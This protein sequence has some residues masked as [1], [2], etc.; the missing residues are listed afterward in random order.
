MIISNQ[1]KNG[2]L[3]AIRTLFDASTRRAI[4]A[5]PYLSS[6]AADL[7]GAINITVVDR[8]DLITTFKPN[9]PEQITK[10]FQIKEVFDFINGLERKIEFR[11]WIDNQLH[12]KVYIALADS[13]AAM[14]VSSANLTHNGLKDNH[15][16]GV[17]LS[18]QEQIDLV[19]EALFESIDYS[20]VTETQIKRAC[21]F[22]D[23]YKRDRSE[24]FKAPDFSEL[25][26]L[27]DCYK[28]HSGDSI[29]TKY[30]LKPYGTT[31]YP[32]TL[33]GQQDFS[34][35]HQNLHFSKRPPK[36]VRKGDI[37]IT[38][39]VGAGSILSYFRVTGP[40]ESVSDSMLEHEP[41]LERWPWYMEGRNQSREFGACWWEHNLS[42]HDLLKEF[43]DAHPDKAVTF[44]GGKTLGTL[45]RGSDKVRITPEFAHFIIERI[46]A[47]SHSQPHQG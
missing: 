2:H 13:H 19:A 46:E 32:I 6:N 36:S 45:N 28:D 16:W 25:D 12:G 47:A 4:I 18:D 11:L 40:L 1:R 41:H 33:E 37:V 24:G 34:A 44:V 43:V 27:E 22:A 39:A 31:E 26:I 42:R 10:P 7:L 15:E 20:E 35:L 23:Q 14:I 29:E 8:F 21:L 3:E 5:S 38:T 30:W 17:H 9:D